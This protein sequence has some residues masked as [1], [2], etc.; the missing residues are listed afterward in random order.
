MSSFKR[1]PKSVRYVMARLR[2]WMQPAVW[3][4]LAILC[5]GGVFIWE[6]SVHPE[7]LSIDGEDVANSNNPTLIAGL[8]A[9]D[10]AIAAEIDSV[11]MLVNKF[12][13]SNSEFGLL[14]SPVGKGLFNEI[15]DRKPEIPQP[16]SAS[17][18]PAIN[19]FLSIPNLANSA[20]SATKNNPRNSSLSS[21]NTIAALSSSRD[22]RLISGN[23]TMGAE[24]STDTATATLS[25][26]SDSANSG[27][28]KDNPLPLSPLQAAMKKYIAANPTAR[29]TS[30]EKT[31]RTAKLSDRPNATVSPTNLAN[32]LPTMTTAQGS[33]NPVN[34][35]TTLAPILAQTS[36]VTNDSPQ[37]SNTAT[38]LPES[39]T[40]LNSRVTVI[41]EINTQPVTLTLPK[42]PYQTNLSGSEIVPRTQSSVIPIAT[43]S[44]IQLLPN[45][46]KS[47]FPNTTVESKIVNP[48]FSPNSTNSQ[49]KSV[50]PSQPNFGVVP[51]NTI[52]QGLQPIQPQPFPAQRQIPGRYLGG[53]EINT[54]SNP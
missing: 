51:Q 35:P 40:R 41:P 11:P 34:L 32:L 46:G 7:R 49:F 9:E 44:P 43:P 18:Q 1:F 15:R 6:V 37:V 25:E 13:R 54:F 16:S 20:G 21:L 52:N 2:Y 24:G 47:P 48:Q 5:A 26:V 10:T 14:G 50:Q 36:T 27:K 42:N 19:T 33:A 8:S 53:G 17:K 45:V 38:T 30:T 23:K 31:T 4:P 12:N 39:Y 22:G 29:A 3:T 28:Q